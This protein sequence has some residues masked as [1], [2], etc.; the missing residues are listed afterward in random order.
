MQ[1]G[2]ILALL[3]ALFSSLKGIA[4]KHVSRDFSSIQIGYMGQVYGVL[5]LLPLAAWRY[6]QTGLN[7]TPGIAMALTV[8]TVIVL[9][10]TYLYI[11]A[12]RITDISV[13]EPLRNTSPIFVA[14]LEPLIL[15]IQMEALIIAAAVMGSAGAYILVA[16]K[17]L[18][19]PLENMKNRG[20][21]LSILVAFILSLYSIAQRFGAT[22]ADPLLFIYMTYITSLIG[23][24]IWKKKEGETIKPK[25]YLRKDVF[26]LGTVTAT[27]VV[28]GIYAYSMI[29]A[30]EVTIIKQTSAAFS[31]ILGGKFFKE[32]QLTR[33]LIG[34]LIIGL[35]V[36]LVA[37]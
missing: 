34:A 23:F 17:S 15:N 14:L 33:K 13:T 12:L 6:T 1:L 11:E 21:L 5:L 32:Q 30:S 25:T 4:R 28:L 9:A 8:S 2:I 20:A 19:T 31:V 16:E 7:L 22:K 26:A 3:A 10:S 24:W 35:G 29:T 18:L 36:L 37:L 27:G